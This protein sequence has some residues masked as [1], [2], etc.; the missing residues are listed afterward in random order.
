MAIFC[1]AVFLGAKWP[2]GVGPL[3]VCLG[4]PPPPPLVEVA[5]SGV[6]PGIFC[7]AV[8]W[9]EVRLTGPADGSVCLAVY[10]VYGVRMDPDENVRE[11]ELL[12]ARLRAG[13]PADLS[14]DLSRDR[15]RLAEL[16]AALL[17]WRR[18]GGFAPGSAPGS[19]PRSSSSRLE[20]KGR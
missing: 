3:E 5:R 7:P 17:A 10:P 6:F 14:R 19:A 18:S 20:A 11:Q 15:E 16:R 2:R 12:M 9:G 8:F 4:L 1:P 13:R